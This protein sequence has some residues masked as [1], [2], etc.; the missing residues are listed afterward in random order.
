M[1]IPKKILEL[2]LFFVLFQHLNSNPFVDA[3]KQ[4]NKVTITAVGDITLGSSFNY[5]FNKIKKENGEEIALNYP[6]FKVRKYLDGSIS[7]ANLEGTFTNQTKETIKRFNF[8]GSPEYAKCLQRGS[9]ELVNLANNHS[10]DYR[11]EGLEETLE[12]L[13]KENIFYCGAGKNIE[14]ARKPKIERQNGLKIAF[15][16]YADVGR[17]FTALKEKA[18]VAPYFE[19]YLSEDIKNA[20]EEANIIVVSLHFGNELRAYPNNRQIEIA[21]KA[22]DYGAHIVL[23]HHP[24]VIEG[25]EKYKQ[26]VIFYS[27]GNFC[28]G[29]NINP[30]DKDGI[31]AKIIVS[32]EGVEDFYII[33]IKTSNERNNF[34]PS[35]PDKQERER[36]IKKIEKRT[37]P[38]KTELK[39]D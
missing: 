20:R 5:I 9:I 30:K 1:S 15:L 22:I 38:F 19:K 31:I 18:G 32:Y 23:G 28:F 4:K 36:I 34:Q 7:I 39:F 16:G 33:P 35:Y 6:F 29:G 12:N 11:R 14:E 21:H 17:E 2:V 24:H 8:K 27:L 13:D 25:V 37:E 26:G 10:L 3:I